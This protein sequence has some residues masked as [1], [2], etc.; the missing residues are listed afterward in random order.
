M[1]RKAKKPTKADRPRV[2]AQPWEVTHVAKKHGVEPAIVR[3][4]KKKVGTSRR[5]V[6]NWL[7]GFIY[8]RDHVA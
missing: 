4:A 5:D 1:A 7:R 8:H 6:E 3:A 2:S